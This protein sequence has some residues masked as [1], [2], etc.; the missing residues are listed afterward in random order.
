MQQS[1]PTC[2]PLRLKYEFEFILDICFAFCQVFLFSAGV[3][4]TDKKFSK[5][6]NTKHQS[7]AKF[8]FETADL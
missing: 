1:M 8:G 5:Q 3:Q 4:N 2:D 7:T 6:L